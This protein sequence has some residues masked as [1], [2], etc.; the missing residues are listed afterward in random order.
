MRKVCRKS[1]T[2]GPSRGG[3][4]NLFIFATMN[5]TVNGK[6]A[7][8]HMRGQPG[9]LKVQACV[10]ASVIVIVIGVVSWRPTDF[11][12]ILLCH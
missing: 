9:I 2:D 6:P 8:M 10:V 3:F 4:R 7:T 11:A 5:G 12:D 1:G